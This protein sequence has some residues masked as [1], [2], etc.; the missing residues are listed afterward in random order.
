MRRTLSFVFII[1]CAIAGLWGGYWL[2]HLA[3][4]SK[5]ADW[6]QQI[7]GGAGAIALSIVCALVGIAI[8]AAILIV[9]THRT[10]R[11]LLLDGTSATAT[12]LETKRAGLTIRS[13]KDT[14]DKVCC[15][16]N[17]RPFQGASFPSKAC[18]FVTAA[19]ETALR[20][21]TVVEVRYDPEKPKRAAIV[22][23][24]RV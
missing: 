15:R 6:P 2:G 21:D 22:G 17:V 23:P 8:A 11:R 4:W 20:P 1:V 19:Q 13:T 9:P 3:G 10:T 16:L 18:Q 12:I 24:A 7:G 14:W 5:N